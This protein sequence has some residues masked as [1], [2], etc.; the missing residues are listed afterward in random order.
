MHSTFM[1]G[2]VRV[3]RCA[4]SRR[5]SEGN[6]S[7]MRY[8]AATFAIVACLSI[9]SWA[10]ASGP[11]ATGACCEP[12]PSS[13]LGFVVS[14]ADCGIALGT[15]QGD[16]TDCTACEPAVPAVSDWGVASLGLLL[17]AGLTI[18]FRPARVPAA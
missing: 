15:Y 12:F 2:K 18:K 1:R 8:L 17:L 13:G 6:E 4:V 16:G 7:L 9:A 11:S 14:A 10:F 3:V 5:L